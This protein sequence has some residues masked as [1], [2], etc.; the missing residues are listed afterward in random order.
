M[1]KLLLVDDE[2]IAIEALKKNIDMEALS[3]SV[4]DFA[5]DVEDAR[6]MISQNGYD[7]MVCDIE[8]PG[9]TGIDLME[10]INTNA[11]DIV[12]IFLTCHPEFSYAKKAVSLGVS[13]YL[14]K[15]IDSVE[16][17]EAL[18]K[19][20]ERKKN[21]TENRR[22]RVIASSLG[23]DIVE[24]QESVNQTEN[25][26]REA[27]AYIRENIG[28]ETLDVKAV[29]AHVYLNPD[30][31][32]RLFKT[33]HNTSIKNYIISTRITLAEELLANSLLS[34]SKIAMSCGYSHMAHFSK[35]FKQETGMTPN[36]YRAK[37]RKE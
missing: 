25:A 33:Y 3:I 13:D 29:A 9:E 22:A 27:S 28:S 36:E 24:K 11:Y 8:M 10:W 7:L 2:A 30:Y 14:I 16:L 1:Y 18:A 12:T 21:M 31:L 37:Y 19:A 17:N 35:M 6:S 15:S 4:I 34:I 23:Q 32:S 20:I 26:V 5:Y